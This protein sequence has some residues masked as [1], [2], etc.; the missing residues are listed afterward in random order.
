MYPQAYL[1]AETPL[2][3]YDNPS[4]AA[5]SGLN[6]NFN[7]GQLSGEFHPQFLNAP[8]HPAPPLPP[9]Q[10]QMPSY[11]KNV[12]SLHMA[13]AQGQLPMRPPQTPP[14]SIEFVAYQTSDS[15][16]HQLQRFA[17]PS[18]HYDQPVA[19]CFEVEQEPLAEGPAT[20]SKREPVL[21][22]SGKKRPQARVAADDLKGE[23]QKSRSSQTRSREMWNHS[24][25]SKAQMK[26]LEDVIKLSSESESELAGSGA[27][28]EG[29]GEDCPGEV[30]SW[31]FD[32]VK[33]GL[34][35]H[36]KELAVEYL[37]KSD[38]YKS[39]RTKLVQHCITVRIFN[40]QTYALK[41]HVLMDSGQMSQSIF[42]SHVSAEQI[43]NFW[44][45]NA[46]KKYKAVQAQLPHTG[47]GDPDATWIEEGSEVSKQRPLKR[48]DVMFTLTRQFSAP[49]L[50]AFYQ[51]KMFDLIDAV[52]SAVE[53]NC[54][55]NSADPVSHSKQDCNR[56]WGS[57]RDRSGSSGEPAF[58]VQAFEQ[59]AECNKAAQK[60]EKEKLE[61]ARQHKAHK[62]QE[63]REKAKMCHYQD[64]HEAQAAHEVQWKRALEMSNSENAAV[65][66]RGFKLM[67]RI[68][69]E[70]EEA[71]CAR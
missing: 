17:A 33:W 26:K 35:Q 20:G 6:D 53:R 8:C 11:D 56:D 22:Q 21:F 57:A 60:V 24:C 5:H 2:E 12:P 4:Q 13:P 36:E 30:E 23:I 25:L 19:Y 14:N 59:F 46:F 29:E 31:E 50:L 45:N 68:E 64:Q 63:Q 42:K 9:Q 41:W 51:S 48:T 65:R 55:Y 39:L 70:E 10:W 16:P 49:V 7:F 3:V 18:Q 32:E 40:S 34:D 47:G 69:E 28:G 27:D 61:L 43:R 66:E 38:C 37:V 58:I 52:D 15:Q 71:E 54:K 62:E 44:N 67:D 1:W